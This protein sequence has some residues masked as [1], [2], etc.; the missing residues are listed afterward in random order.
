MWRGKLSPAYYGKIAARFLPLCPTW[1]DIDDL[2]QEARIADWQRR[3]PRWGITDA[4][5]AT[6]RMVRASSKRERRWLGAEVSLEALLI[7]EDND[8]EDLPGPVG[9][10]RALFLEHELTEWYHATMALHTK[11]DVRQALTQQSV[12]E[13]Q[14]FEWSMED[15]TGAEIATRL[16]LSEGRVSQILSKVKQDLRASAGS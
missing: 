5:R 13:R 12:R 14:I 6:H 3:D 15:E 10:D 9:S 4:L 11:L 8:H 16:G 2:A 7:P 1:L